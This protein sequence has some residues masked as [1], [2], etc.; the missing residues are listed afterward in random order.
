MTGAALATI[1]TLIVFLL[2][3]R[4]IIRGV[5]MAGLKG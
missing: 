4:Y 5:A 2:F 3:Q 1:P